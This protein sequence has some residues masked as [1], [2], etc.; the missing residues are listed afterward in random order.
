MALTAAS[1]DAA[2]LD[3]L[4]RRQLSRLG[5]RPVPVAIHTAEDKSTAVLESLG[6]QG[7]SYPFIDT[8]LATPAANA[9]LALGR[10]P[11]VRD[12]EL[13]DSGILR[14]IY[15]LLGRLEQ[16]HLYIRTG[17]HDVA[18]INLSLAP[19]RALINSRPRRTGEA[20][21][22]R[23]VEAFTIGLGVPVT[24]PAGNDGP[25]EGFLN[26]WATGAG[27]TVVTAADE[28]GRRLWQ[29][30]SRPAGDIRSADWLLVAAWG[31]DSIT[32]RDLRYEADLPP[33]PKLVER[34]G[35]ERALLLTTV[36]GTSFAAPQI[37]VALCR[38]HQA[39]AFLRGLLSSVT[40]SRFAVSPHIRAL[41]DTAIDRDQP[42]FDKRQV[43]RREKYGGLTV[44][45]SFDH[46]RAVMEAFKSNGI[47]VDLT[48][49]TNPALRFIKTIARPMPDAGPAGGLGF[50]DADAASSFVARMRVSDF[51]RLFADE[52]DERLEGWI[53]ALTEGDDPTVLTPE[54]A[55]AIPNYC[56]EYDLSLSLPLAPSG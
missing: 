8:V 34:F 50:V 27:T 19:P 22:R 31:V 32:T 39:T 2:V 51:V 35:E 42:L 17:I 24:M 13:V 30:A 1:A 40:G 10:D 23:A 15:L 25:A 26:P 6:G 55:E 37:S 5:N 52:G 20:T 47:D 45:T 14:T 33:D 38:L 18:S 48:F 54:V 11:A 9:V 56:D 44:E 43:E 28:A 41:V 46:K 53:S 21:V 3:A 29:Q 7:Y 49:R 4:E 12:V 36:T 16:L